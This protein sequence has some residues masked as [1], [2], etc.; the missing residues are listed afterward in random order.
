M[1]TN[2]VCLIRWGNEYDFLFVV[3]FSSTE[4]KMNH[5]PNGSVEY[6]QVVV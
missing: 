4:F 6:L 2:Q 3:G 5:M 1:N